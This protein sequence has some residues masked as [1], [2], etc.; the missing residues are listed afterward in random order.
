MD[1]VG[2]DGVEVISGKV[3]GAPLLK[4]SCVPADFA[5]DCLED[6]E[7]VDGISALFPALLSIYTAPNGP[8]CG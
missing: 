5:A 2:Y 4:S 3:G 8:S 6:G 7:T 1:W